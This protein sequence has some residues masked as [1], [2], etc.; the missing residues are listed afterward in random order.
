[1]FEARL[2]RASIL[3]DMIEAIKDLI[4]EASFECSENEIMMKAMDSDRISIVHISLK[5][6]CFFHYRCDRRISLGIEI[7]NLYKILTCA[8]DEDVL[9]FKT[10]NSQ[11]S[12]TIL[13]ESP[14]QDRI[15]D[16]KLSLIDINRLRF[17][18]PNEDVKCMIR[19]PANEFQRII[20]D[21]VIISEQ[22]TISCADEGIRFSVIG[23]CGAVSVLIGTNSDNVV[24]NMKEP[25]E[26]ELSSRYLHRFTKT[27]TFGPYVVISMSPNTPITFRYPI[28]E[29]GHVT[30]YLAPRIEE[31]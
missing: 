12:L 27:A 30:Y 13:F 1:M 4:T 22:C 17:Q 29:N 19:M 20:S 11:D 18:I 10:N 15:S 6:T 24:I 16:C 28:A 14:S 21:L 3:K 31:D 8:R 9:T 5:S 7:P 23:E 26:L 25:V 2:I